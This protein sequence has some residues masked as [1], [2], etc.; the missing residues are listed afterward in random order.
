LEPLIAKLEGDAQKFRKMSLAQSLD[1]D[2]ESHIKAGHVLAKHV[3]PKEAAPSFAE[4]ASAPDED[5][6]TQ[7]RDAIAKPL[8]ELKTIAKR[9]KKEAEDTRA[10]LHQETAQ[11]LQADT[12]EPSS[13]LETQDLTRKGREQLRALL[14]PWERDRKKEEAA[15]VEEKKMERRYDD[16]AKKIEAQIEAQ[17]NDISKTL[18]KL[19][20]D[21][22]RKPN[23]HPPTFPKL[24]QRPEE[25][26]SIY[27]AGPPTEK[28][29]QKV[30]NPLPVHKPSFLQE[31]SKMPEA[32][33][34]ARHKLRALHN[35]F[36]KMA[37]NYKRKA[38][39]DRSSF[40]Q[41]EDDEE[42]DS[43]QSP[44]DFEKYLEEESK[45]PMPV[46]KL[47][48]TKLEAARK[49][50]DKI[51]K[52]VKA[53]Q[54]Q[55]MHDESKLR[56]HMMPH[57][58]AH[59]SSL[60]ETE[61][62]HVD[63]LTSV[64][65][66]LKKIQKDMKPEDR[67]YSPSELGKAP[68]SS[69]LQ[70]D[71]TMEQVQAEANALKAHMEQQRQLYRDDAT[72]IR[73]RAEAAAPSGGDPSA[74]ID[75]LLERVHATSAAFR[76]ATKA[77]ANPSPLASSFAETKAHPS[78]AD[79]EERFKKFAKKME[80]EADDEARKAREQMPSSMLQEGEAGQAADAD[81][82]FH[83][84]SEQE[85]QYA[86]VAA[87]TNAAM[88]ARS[89]DEKKLADRFVGE[90]TA[91]WKQ[92][93]EERDASFQHQLEASLGKFKH[94]M[95]GPSSFAETDATVNETKGKKYEMLP[96]LR[97]HGAPSLVEEKFQDDLTA[98]Q[99]R[100][101]ADGPAADP[102]DYSTHALDE[103]QSVIPADGVVA[104][105]PA[106]DSVI[107]ADGASWED[108]GAAPSSSWLE[109]S[110]KEHMRSG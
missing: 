4:T 47:D 12:A 62:E 36:S 85:R 108:A 96:A 7:Y 100:V 97:T 27:D 50:I 77:E 39:Y 89:D 65:K 103:P 11:Q 23:F 106:S 59:P 15:E 70:A 6:Q 60:L 73:Q 79:V 5:Y 75:S 56:K 45:S 76:D 53:D 3:R 26:T 2:M 81:W 21:V 22:H 30:I 109:R 9:Y 31:V 99:A 86:E 41:E 58:R 66:T 83:G 67:A 18:K 8:H 20:D 93:M 28:R 42:D 10:W 64:Q 69:F 54:R 74:A 80:K 57:H 104:P 110:A 87:R 46:P 13:F 78:I 71:P 91:A 14:S 92:K 37:D 101:A 61:P 105:L 44:S 51:E 29:K 32:V 95:D 16:K 82:L 98:L 24:R 33:D 52:S 35:K 84:Q 40:L 63:A 55:F 90:D 34:I 94:F 48:F 43:V 107:G 102:A 72:A 38:V 19:E 88:S 68:P 17:H 1:V 25:T 49:K